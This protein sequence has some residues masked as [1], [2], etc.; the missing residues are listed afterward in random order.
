[1]AKEAAYV[2]FIYL[3]MGTDVVK[4]LFCLM[5]I[6]SILGIIKALRLGEKVSIKILVWGIITKLLL[7]VI[8]MTVALIAKG[9]SFDLTQFVVIII[10]IIVVSEGIS[11]ITNII[12]IKTKQQLENTDFITKLLISIKNVL[13]FAMKKLFKAID[14][15]KNKI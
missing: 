2:L 9:L 11:I 8:P 14:D 13:T 6:D 15:E 4:I 3:G 5:V 1:M 7:L 10:D 12:S